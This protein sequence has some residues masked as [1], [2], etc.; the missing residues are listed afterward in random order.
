VI[1]DYLIYILFS[2][3]C[4][5]L[6]INMFTVYSKL[7]HLLLDF[8]CNCFADL[9]LTIQPMHTL[10]IH[11]QILASMSIVN[12]VSNYHLQHIIIATKS[13]HGSVV[14][15]INSHMNYPSSILTEGQCSCKSVTCQT[16][17]H[18]RVHNKECMIKDVF[19]GNKFYVQNC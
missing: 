14:K 13:S 15:A 18:V 4:G 7:F 12:E 9:H 3:L 2:S 1:T 11:M 17:R 8:V 16:G 19:H 10:I 5:S 6:L